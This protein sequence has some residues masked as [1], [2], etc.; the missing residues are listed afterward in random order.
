VGKKGFLA[1][2]V[3]EKP[4]ERSKMKKACLRGKSLENEK[5]ASRVYRLT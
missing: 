1:P 3:V 2:P 4:K 5:G